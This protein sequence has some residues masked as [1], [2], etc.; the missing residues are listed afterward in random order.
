[1]YE[2][3]RVA[4]AYHHKEKLFHSILCILLI[5]HHLKIFVIAF[6]DDETKHNIH[7][8]LSVFIRLRSEQYVHDYSYQNKHVTIS[9]FPS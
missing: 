3:S 2:S 5:R 4:I 9:S 8:W 7:T 1:M 6:F